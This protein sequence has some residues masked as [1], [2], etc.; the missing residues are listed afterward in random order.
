MLACGGLGKYNYNTK[1]QPGLPRPAEFEPGSHA[2]AV[3]DA[4]SR[5]APIEKLP[6][7]MPGLRVSRV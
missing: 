1:L 2:G 5:R 4:A 6:V 3:M 7:E